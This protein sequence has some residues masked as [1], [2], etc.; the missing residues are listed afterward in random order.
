MIEMIEMI[1]M[2]DEASGCVVEG[3]K[4]SVTAESISSKEFFSVK[5]KC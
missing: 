5:K 3:D 4:V 1:E 2:I